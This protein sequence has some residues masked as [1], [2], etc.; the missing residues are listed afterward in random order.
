MRKFYVALI[1]LFAAIHISA[2][3]HDGITYSIIDENT[4]KITNGTGATGDVVIPE[5]VVDQA[6]GKSYTVV[7]VGK[8]AFA[9]APMTSLQLPKTV[10]IIGRVAFSY[11]TMKSITL[12]EGLEE[13]GYNAFSHCAELESIEI[14]NSV[15]VVGSESPITGAS[16]SAFFGCASLRSVKLPETL[17]KIDD[18]T[19]KECAALESIEIPTSVTYIGNQAFAGCHSLTNVEIPDNVAVIGESAFGDCMNLV[20]IKLPEG[21]E[22]IQFSTFTAC[23]KL[24]HITIPESV[25][26]I[27]KQ[28]FAS[29]FALKEVNIPDAVEYIATDAFYGCSDTETITLGT[30]IRR[31]GSASLAVWS[32]DEHNVATWKLKDI[33]CHSTVV[34]TYYHEVV[35]HELPAD[36]FFATEDVSEEQQNEFY[37]TVVLHVPDEAVEDYKNSELWNRFKHIIPMSQTSIAT[38]TEEA[39]QLTFD[40]ETARTNS[41]N[42]IEVYSI[43][44]MRIAATNSNELNIQDLNAGIYILKSGHTVKKIV[45][46]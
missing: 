45:K 6:D 24:E 22:K 14:P 25:V 26:E 34:P 20:S 43:T 7:E 2:F 11:S 18:I 5:T 40:G 12:A 30:G 37:N 17:E 39:E 36:F 33:Y 1:A 41:E 29:C 32:V 38:E 35:L 9:Y 42:G 28:A 16:G 15:K 3:E 27:A 44:G 19:F 23:A 4:V 31:I 21:L 8:Q 10:K 46:E 13:I